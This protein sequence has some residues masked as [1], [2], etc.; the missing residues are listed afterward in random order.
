M[1]RRRSKQ[2]KK[3]VENAVQFEHKFSAFF[4]KEQD[5]KK[6]M[7]RRDFIKIASLAGGAGILAACKTSDTATEEPKTA[8][9]IVAIYL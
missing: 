7:S 5:M 3:F 6:N 2:I 8:E 1:E 9:E 4:K